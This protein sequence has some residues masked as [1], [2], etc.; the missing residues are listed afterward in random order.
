MANLVLEEPRK[1]KKTVGHRREFNGIHAGAGR[2]WIGSPWMCANA[3]AVNQ[4]AISVLTRLL[5]ISPW[6]KG[7]IPAIERSIMKSDLGLNPS[8]DGNVS[9]RDSAAHGGAPA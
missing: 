8:S 2:C 9:G 7:T 6:D 4:V 1:M 5:M 3:T